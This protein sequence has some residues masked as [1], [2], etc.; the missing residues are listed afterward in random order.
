MAHKKITREDLFPLF[1]R[2]EMFREV[3]EALGGS[4]GGA[5]GAAAGGEDGGLGG[6]LAP[7]GQRGA[8][9]GTGDIDIEGLLA[10]AQ[11]LQGAPGTVPPSF[12]NPLLA[13]PTATGAANQRVFAGAKHGPFVFFPSTSPVDDRGPINLASAASNFFNT[14]AGQGFIKELI[15]GSEARRKKKLKGGG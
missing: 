10:L 9:D 4:L 11:Q 3:V 6:F 5:P 7:P 15:G 1:R 2:D 14:E 13:T 12:T 8:G